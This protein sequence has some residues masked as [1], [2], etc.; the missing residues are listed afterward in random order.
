MGVR[1]SS[2]ALS[3]TRSATA[4]TSATTSRSASACSPT[5]RSSSA[6]RSSTSSTS[7]S[8]RRTAS[9]WCR[10]APSTSSAAR[11]PTTPTRQKDV[12][13]AVTT[14]VE[15]VRIAVKANSGITSIA[16][17]ERQEGRH[18]HRHHLGA[19]A[20]QERARQ[21]RQLR[22]GLRQGPRRQLPAARVGPRRRL[23]DG[24]H[25]S[26]PATSPRPK[27][28]ADF[29]IVGEVLSVEPIAIM[30]RKDD[31]AFK[32][33]VD[34]SI[35]G[36]DQVGRDRQALGQV[37]HEADPAEQHQ[38]RPGRQRLDQG[39]PGRIRTTSRW[40]TTRRSDANRQPGAVPRRSTCGPA[41]A[42]YACRRSAG[43]PAPRLF[44]CATS[45]RG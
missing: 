36:D 26:W 32:K 28:P 17:L 12:A 35:K 5:S 34:D 8:P 19:D 14:F 38:G 25:R 3:A 41:S 7:R 30:M 20:A 45:R 43:D 11:P 23:R 16:Q 33:A 39:T 1:E 13:F 21:R 27:N 9:R 2:G 42:V 31:P 18:H 37:V 4:S 6:C 29:K 10:T 22:R 24:R 40:K 15:E 44:V